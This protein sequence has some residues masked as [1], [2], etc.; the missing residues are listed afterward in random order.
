MISHP[1]IA[2]NKSKRVY[3]NLEKENDVSGACTFEAKIKVYMLPQNNSAAV[4]PVKIKVNFARV[5]TPHIR[6]RAHIISIPMQ[7]FQLYI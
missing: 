4:S 5:F 1:M 7:S 6:I 3:P 2:Q